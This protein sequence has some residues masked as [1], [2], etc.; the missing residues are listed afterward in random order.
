MKLTKIDHI[1][2]NCNN[3]ANSRK[4]YENVL[5]LKQLEVVD[6][7][8]HVLHY[9]Q[10]P[11]VK[12]ELIE[13]KNPQKNWK[14]GNTDTG[15]YRHFAIYTDD[16]QEIKARCEKEGY[17]INLQPAYIAEIDK[18]IML[19]TDPNGVEIEIIQEIGGEDN[20]AETG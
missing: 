6:M 16:L 5:E 20:N 13:Y 2:I 4:F 14:I 18:T 11:G 3:L 12:L 9:Y 17:G 7:G 8:D 19:I 10:L 1:T 15:V